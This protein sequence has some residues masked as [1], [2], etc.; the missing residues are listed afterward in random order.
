MA[1]SVEIAKRAKK[2]LSSL[3]VAT[4]ERIAEAIGLLG[5]DPDDPRLDVKTLTDDKEARYRL[6]VGSFRVKFNRDDVVKIISIIKVG[7]RRDVYR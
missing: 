7:H 2:Q 1:Y 4:Q 3:S 5:Y 6:R